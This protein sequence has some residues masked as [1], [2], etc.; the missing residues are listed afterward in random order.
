MLGGLRE[1][2]LLAKHHEIPDLRG[3]Y[4]RP[5]TGLDSDE[6]DGFRP[7]LTRNDIAPLPEEAWDASAGRGLRAGWRSSRSLHFAQAWPA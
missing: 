7:V 2:Q 3:T 4:A 1:I 5:L 6:I